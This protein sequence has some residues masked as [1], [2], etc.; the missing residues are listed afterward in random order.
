MLTDS[1]KNAV[2]DLGRASSR[3]GMQRRKERGGEDACTVN[4]ETLEHKV[5]SPQPDPSCHTMIFEAIWISHPPFQPAIHSAHSRFKPS[6]RLAGLKPLIPVAL[7]DLHSIFGP[8]GGSRPL[9]V[10]RYHHPMEKV[11][12]LEPIPFSLLSPGLLGR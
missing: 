1:P 12:V 11:I 6:T 10:L 9:D 2:Q 8:A 5:S 4:L 3:Q 7:E